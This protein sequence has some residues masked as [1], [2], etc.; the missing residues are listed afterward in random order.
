MKMVDLIERNSSF[1]LFM[2]HF[3]IDFRVDDLTVGQVCK[4]YDISESLFLSV[5]NLY[6]GLKSKSEIVLSNKD[7]L[8][9]IEFLRNS[10]I[11]YRKYK[12]P[13]IKS[14]IHQLQEEN[15]SKELLLLEKFFN[16]YLKEVLEHLDYEENVA[17]PYFT[18]LVTNNNIPCDDKYTA[19]EYHEHHT[20]IELKLADLKKL[21]L[22]HIKISNSL[23]L[24]RRLLT[25]LLELEFDLYIHS[26]I[27]E[28]IL[29][30]VG[31][32]LEKDCK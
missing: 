13:E 11:Y 21:L 8:Q 16:T 31:S 24:R 20:D 27:E 12:Y 9:L 15:P 19:K 10:H 23:N 2:Q 22:K 7:I 30:P 3:K 1:L 18:E 32:S 28:T 4:E 5:G 26:L 6:N 25:A 17:F 14:Y 29:V